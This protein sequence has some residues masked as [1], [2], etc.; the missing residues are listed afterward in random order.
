L[1]QIAL[2]GELPNYENVA[3]V[4]EYVQQKHVTV[5]LVEKGPITTWIRG[6][7]YQVANPWPKLI[8]KLAKPHEVGGLILY[9]LDGTAPCRSAAA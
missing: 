5:I 9:R 1:A 7:Q 8:G 6:V 3:P 2:N 4:R